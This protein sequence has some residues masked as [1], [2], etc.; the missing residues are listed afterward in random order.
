MLVEFI[1]ALKRDFHNILEGWHKRL[2]VKMG[3]KYPSIYAFL[4]ELQQEQ[5]DTTTMLEQLDVGQRVKNSL[6]SKIDWLVIDL[7]RQ[8]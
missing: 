3:K 2:Q 1:E 4:F 7:S 6:S 5:T 8:N